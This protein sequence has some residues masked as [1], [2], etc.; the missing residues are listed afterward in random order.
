MYAQDISCVCF[1]TMLCKSPADEV[2]FA[3]LLMARLSIGK[4]KKERN[5]HY[6]VNSEM[7]QQQQ[8]T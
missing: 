6:N 8:T 4:K 2:R 3:L 5:T 1:A 7:K